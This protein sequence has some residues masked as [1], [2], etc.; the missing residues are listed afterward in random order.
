[1]SNLNYNKSF[2]LE[3]VVKE[4]EFLPLK[5]YS[6]L[7]PGKHIGLKFVTVSDIYRFFGK[8]KSK[9]GYYGYGLLCHSPSEEM[10]FILLPCYFTVKKIEDLYENSTLDN[11]D[12]VI[13]LIRNPKTN[14][15]HLPRPVWENG[16]LS[17]FFNTFAQF[18]LYKVYSEDDDRCGKVLK[19]VPT[20]NIKVYLNF[21][22]LYKR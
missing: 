16:V 13:T 15:Y 2:I 10:F 9:S 14:K 12:Q 7:N 4:T 17:D 5:F 22:K 20:E 1:M 11:E 19:I 3:H 18:Y 8:H 6:D 21:I